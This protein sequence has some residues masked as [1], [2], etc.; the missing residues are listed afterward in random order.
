MSGPAKKL[1]KKK[2]EDIHSGLM[3]RYRDTQGFT[4]PI[5]GAE[6]EAVKKELLS[7]ILP[8]GYRIG[9]GCI[10]DSSGFETGQ[11]DAVIEEPF[12]LSLPIASPNNRLY[13][14]DT[15]AA[16]FEIKSDL[17][18]Q[19]AE[20]L[21]KCQEI[22][23]AERKIETGDVVIVEDARIPTFVIA[24]K[25]PKLTDDVQARLMNQRGRMHPNGVLVLDKEV[26]VGRTSGASLNQENGWYEGHGKA[27]SMLAFLCCLL[28]TL[29]QE[30]TRP[31]QLFDYKNLL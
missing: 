10:V 22:R 7:L 3:E 15:V 11:V 16:A 8:P 4:S 28:T 1:F 9:S 19:E 5:I 25:G 17:Y 13:L 12:S 2:L 29:K 31:W 23:T 21:K 14:A 26:F 18:R 27:A 20:A 30:N 24:F 6:R